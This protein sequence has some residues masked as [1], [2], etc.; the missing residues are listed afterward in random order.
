MTRRLGEVEVW[1]RKG[2]AVQISGLVAE[3]E[4][5]YALEAADPPKPKAKGSNRPFSVI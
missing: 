2:S 4:A 3:S 5:L 1:N